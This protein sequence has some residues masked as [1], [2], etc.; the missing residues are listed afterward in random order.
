MN[1]Y[2]LY[3][4]R[5]KSYGLE[6]ITIEDMITQG[7]ITE[8]RIAEIEKELQTASAFETISPIGYAVELNFI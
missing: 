2:P 1:N 3:E 5:M 4:N 8:E 6:D 7:M